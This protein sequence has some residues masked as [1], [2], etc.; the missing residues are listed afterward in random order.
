MCCVPAPARPQSHIRYPLTDILGVVGNVRVLRVLALK[1]RPSA[2]TELA[3]AAGLTGQ[4]VRNVLNALV[5]QGIVSIRGSGRVQLYEL[6]A[7]H[8]LA[9]TL[10]QLF[11]A[12]QAR[13]DRLLQDIREV[14]GRHGSAVQ[15]V[16]LYGSVARAEDTAQSDI[17]LALVVSSHEVADK[18]REELLQLE[19]AQQVRMSITALTSRELAALADDDPWWSDVVRDARVLKGSEPVSVKRRAA[20]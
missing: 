14:L 20:A 11:R 4:G 6:N 13:W 1:P 17:D 18:V 3:L 8:P 19:D 12:E 2:T 9:E 5:G 7:S 16:W 15:A 10:N